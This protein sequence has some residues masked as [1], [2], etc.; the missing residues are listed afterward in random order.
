MQREIHQAT[1]NHLLRRYQN[2][3][4]NEDILGVEIPPPVQHQ[5]MIPLGPYNNPIVGIKDD[6]CLGEGLDSHEACLD[7]S[8]DVSL[9]YVYKYKFDK[10]GLVVNPIRWEGQNAEDD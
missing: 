1:L 7:S 3:N 4:L 2:V 6:T 9:V 8:V 10:Y 5:Q